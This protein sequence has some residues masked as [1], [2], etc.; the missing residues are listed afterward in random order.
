MTMGTRMMDQVERYQGNMY[1]AGPTGINQRI[2]QRRNRGA[3]FLSTPTYL[4]RDQSVVGVKQKPILQRKHLRL[5]LLELPVGDLQ[6]PTAP[7]VSN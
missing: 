5:E 1:D 2:V 6:F 4:G 7:H 3:A